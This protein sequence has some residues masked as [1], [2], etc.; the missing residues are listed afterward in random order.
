MQVP[1]ALLL[2]HYVSIIYRFFVVLFSDISV[3]LSVIFIGLFTVLADQ[4]ASG[5]RWPRSIRHSKW[6]DRAGGKTGSRL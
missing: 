1:Y 3:R 5:A 6:P 2:S 4:E